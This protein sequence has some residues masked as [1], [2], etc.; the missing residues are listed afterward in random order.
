MKYWLSILPKRFGIIEKF[1]HGYPVDKGFFKGCRTL[2]IGA[3][4]GEHLEYEDLINQDY[5]VLD[6]RSELLSEITKKFPS[7]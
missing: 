5:S 4:L 7:V 3:G 6:M 1:N 2:E